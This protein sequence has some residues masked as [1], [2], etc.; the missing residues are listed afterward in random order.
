MKALILSA[1]LLLP[2]AAHAAGGFPTGTCQL[3]YKGGALMIVFVSTDVDSHNAAAVSFYPSP[4]QHPE[5]NVGLGELPDVLRSFD[6]SREQSWVSAGKLEAVEDYTHARENPQCPG[7]LTI[8]RA[9]G[10]HDV[11]GHSPLV[12]DRQPVKCLCM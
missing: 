3:D 6:P 9:A 2:A 12:L 1:L 10:I 7:T 5:Q 4:Q 11:D 8:T